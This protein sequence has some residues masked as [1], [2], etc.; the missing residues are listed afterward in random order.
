MGAFCY[1]KVVEIMDG[2]FIVCTDYLT[3]LFLGMA[4][5]GAVVNVEPFA[6][7]D[8]KGVYEK[9]RIEFDG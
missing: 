1:Y 8:R 4:S 3:T 5:L 2:T 7:S 6:M 9:E